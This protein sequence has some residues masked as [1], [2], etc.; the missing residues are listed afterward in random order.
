MKKILIFFIVLM[1]IICSVFSDINIK[2]DNKLNITEQEL[3]KVQNE[4]NDLIESLQ[5]ELS[6][7]ENL[8]KI[9]SDLNIELSTA[10]EKIANMQDNGIPIY[11]TE[12]EVNYIAKT[13][14][15]EALG[16]SKIQQSAV[17]WCILNRLDNGHWGNTIRSVVTAPSQFHGYSSS[18]PVT[19]E[20][21]ELVE[22]V[23]LRWNMEKIGAINIG[24]TL[25][26]KFLYFNA[27]G[28]GFGNS[29]ST[30]AGSGERWN[31]DCW[32]PYE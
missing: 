10:N 2:L 21:R 31:F 4:A 32:N 9:I 7:I 6:N 30:Y 16:C 17:V 8:E 1:L 23:L 24:R 22:D 11:F 28:T 25:P 12:E 15:G 18:N 29:F 19:D 3:L 13:V 20:I 5:V 26:E 27:D 14:Y